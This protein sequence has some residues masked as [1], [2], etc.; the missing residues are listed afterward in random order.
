MTNQKRPHLCDLLVHLDPERLHLHQREHPG[1]VLAL[2]FAHPLVLRV[3]RPVQQPLPH[4]GRVHHLHDPLTRRRREVLS[5]AW[6]TTEIQKVRVSVFTQSCS[7][8]DGSN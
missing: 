6:V 5:V 3:L 8:R 2:A 4:V 7:G 1:V